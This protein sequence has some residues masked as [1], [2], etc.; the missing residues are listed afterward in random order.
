[1]TNATD[2]SSAPVDIDWTHLPDQCP[3]VI[4]GEKLGDRKC[5]Q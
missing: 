2:G 1:M 5:N 3:L 4:C